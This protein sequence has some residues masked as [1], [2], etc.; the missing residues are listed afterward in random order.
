MASRTLV[1]NDK[2]KEAIMSLVHERSGKLY[3]SIGNCRL[4][5]K[6]E[7][8][9][10]GFT[11]KTVKLRERNGNDFINHKG[12]VEMCGSGP[13]LFTEGWSYIEKLRVEQ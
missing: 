2:L 10:C 7:Y 12:Q 11:G 8:E 3:I 9:F 6:K 4:D 13:K 5:F 1:L